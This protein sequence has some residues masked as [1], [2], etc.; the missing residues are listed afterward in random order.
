[1]KRGLLS[2]GFN[3][4]FP[5]AGHY[6]IG[7][8]VKALI[9]AIVI[10]FTYAVGLALD[11]QH[12][13]WYEA[14]RGKQFLVTRDD[15][16]PQSKLPELERVNTY[17][18][19]P[20]EVF[21]L[22]ERTSS[23]EIQ[24]RGHAKPGMTLRLTHLKTFDE[25]QIQADYKGFFIFDP[26]PLI[27]GANE[28]EL[29]PAEN[30]YSDFSKTSVG[31]PHFDSSNPNYQPST[32]EK[33]WHFIYKVVFPVL[34]TPLLHWFG[35]TYQGLIIHWWDSIPLVKGEPTIPAPLRDVGFYFIILVCMFNLLILFDGFD[36]CYNQWN[37]SGKF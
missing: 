21:G 17:F 15:S 9:F 8:K 28:I 7:E 31:V 5:G 30:Y 18:D 4:L 27:P 12:Y 35:G 19:D 33:L 13:Y 14:F 10:L 16:A 37:R 23:K 36:T 6:Y 22:E 11:F 3:L 2:I 32:L 24:F 26:L 20:L 29:Q 34:K 1:M 25:V